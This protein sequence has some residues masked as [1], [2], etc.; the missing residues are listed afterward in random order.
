MKKQLKYG[1]SALLGIVLAGTLCLSAIPLEGFAIAQL[2]SA[3]SPNLPAAPS[4]PAPSPPSAAVSEEIT[5]I[6]RLL[7]AQWTITPDAIA[8]APIYLDGRTVFQVSAPAVANQSPAEERAREIQQRLN[9]FARQQQSTPPTVTAEVDEPSNLPVIEVNDQLLMTVTELDAQLSGHAN[10]LDHANILVENLQTAF[11]RYQTE[12]QPAYWQKQAKIAFGL[13]A[14]A[15]LLQLVA[16]RIGR[17]LKRRQV[18]LTSTQTQLKQTGSGQ[19]PVVE[20][21]AARGFDTFFDQIKARL[22]NRQKRKINETERGL[23]WL[24]QIALW[25]GVVLWSLALFPYS[26][27]LSTLLLEWMKIPARILLTVGVAYLA[28]RLS[29]LVIERVGIALQE[30]TQWAPDKS[31]RLSLRF[32]TFSQVAKGLVSALIFG[33]TVLRVLSIGGVDLAPLLAGAGII[34]VGISLAAQ[35]LIKDFINGFLILVEDHFGIGDVITVGELTGS[36]EHINLRITQLRDS[37]G[38]L[39]TIP[40][41]QISIVQN[42]SKDWAQVDLSISVAHSTNLNKAM[43]IIQKTADALAQEVE[44]QR[45]ILEPPELLGVDAV[46]HTG[47]TLRL[48]LKTQPLQQWPVARELRQRIKYA[49]DQEDIAIGVPQEQMAIQWKG[50]PLEAQEVSAIEPQAAHP[51]QPN[52]ETT[53]KPPLTQFH[54]SEPKTNSAES[55]R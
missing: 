48:F 41:S 32:S 12:R 46:D 14:A 9:D 11:E 3:T 27:W 17:R 34:A 52:Q 24:F 5:S 50:L 20:A 8:T 23:L 42:L 16:R 35:N 2:P 18:R 19:N 1:L 4:P 28:V 6:N 26:R 30:G 51:V 13:W 49:F 33:V 55:E 25:I 7:P 43:S 53:T 29:N 39:I 37:E 15:L 22:D 38:R 40:N 21:P 10:P 36:V 54:A 44:W 45:Y 47:I 31:Q